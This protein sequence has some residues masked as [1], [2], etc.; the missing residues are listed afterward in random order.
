MENIIY[1]TKPEMDKVPGGWETNFTTKLDMADKVGVKTPFGRVH[2]FENVFTSDEC[3][4]LVKLFMQSPN[5]EGVSIQGRKDVPDD[6]IGSIRTTVWNTKLAED[7]WEKKFRT[8]LMNRVVF[9][10]KTPTDWWQGNKDRRIW[11]TY[12]ISPMMRF[13]KYE[14]EGQHYAHYDAGYIYPDDNF[15]TLY[16]MV[17]YLTTNDG[18]GSTRFIQDNQDNLDVWERTHEDWTREATDSE[19]LAKSEPIKGNVLIFPHRY[20][21]DVEKYMG[22]GPRIIIRGDIIFRAI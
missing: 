15:R 17:I 12:G 10:S 20:C 21:H 14:K 19:V 22:D 3:D 9:S 6:R 1:T 8:V 7:M 18:G 2:I 13:M 5:F 16:S 11:N 4:E